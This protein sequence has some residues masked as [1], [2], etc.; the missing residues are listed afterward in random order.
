[1]C[2]HVQG[3]GL[4]SL[5]RN[6]AS[7]PLLHCH[8]QVATAARQPETYKV[9]C[10]PPPNQPPRPSPSTLHPPPVFLP[11]SPPGFLFCGA[12]GLLPAD[13]DSTRAAMQVA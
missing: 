5:G 2:V 3:L 13:Q 9:L 12:Y 11:P 10:P 7:A 8:A 6:I 4:R 1:M